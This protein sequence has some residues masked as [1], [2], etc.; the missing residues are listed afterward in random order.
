MHAIFYAAG[1]DVCPGALGE[2]RN[3]DVAPTIL[4]LLGVPP[5]AT[6]EGRPIE[7]CAGPR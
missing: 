6:M 3:I 1:P 7:L 2:V 5:P 4:R